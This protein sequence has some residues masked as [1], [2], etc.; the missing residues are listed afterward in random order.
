M[1]PPPQF[2][3]KCRVAVL[4]SHKVWWVG[5]GSSSLQRYYLS[6]CE[7]SSITACNVSFLTSHPT[8]HLSSSVLLLS[9]TSAR[10]FC[11]RL[12][13][14]LIRPPLARGFL[15]RAHWSPTGTD[16]HLR[17]LH[18][19]L[20]V[21]GSVQQQGSQREIRLHARANWTQG[22]LTCIVDHARYLAYLNPL[23]RSRVCFT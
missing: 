2:K 15:Q 16:R 12:A 4:S 23:I 6:L 13:R 20:C 8:V 14:P 10:G 7:H 9:P 19:F 3:N 1:N 17:E 18:W 11:V 5:H 21:N 22:S